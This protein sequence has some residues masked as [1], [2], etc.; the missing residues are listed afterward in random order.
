MEAMKVPKETFTAFV[1]TPCCSCHLILN[2]P[3]QGRLPLSNR[4]SPVRALF[5]VH[6][7]GGTWEGVDWSQPE[8]NGEQSHIPTWKSF[9]LVSDKR[10][11]ERSKQ[12]QSPNKRTAL[13]EA[14]PIIQLLPV[15]R[16]EKLT[17]ITCILVYENAY[18]LHS[19]NESP[20][21]YQTNF[22]LL[23]VCYFPLRM[24]KFTILVLRV[25]TS[26]LNDMLNLFSNSIKK[27]QKS[28]IIEAHSS[29]AATPSSSPHL[30][31][32][33]LT[34]SVTHLPYVIRQQLRSATPGSQ[35]MNISPLHLGR[36][37]DQ[38]QFQSTPH[39][40]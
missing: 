35:K 7:T 10:T 5:P 37:K 18:L 12:W 13:P 3:N 26:A 9:H 21:A 8:M 16:R 30:S 38:K 15:V 4:Q 32:A 14:I 28:R 33:Y 34:S 22:L 39:L 36:E 29:T 23:K 31:P 2:S 11:S 40:G 17:S 27:P 19:N 25:F 24:I 6:G 20:I 1:H